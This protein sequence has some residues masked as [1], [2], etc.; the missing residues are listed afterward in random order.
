MRNDLLFTGKGHAGTQATLES[1]FTV[2]KIYDAPDRD[3]LLQGLRER[4]RPPAEEDPPAGPGT[5]DDAEERQWS[6]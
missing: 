6:S 4:R 1:E 3:A 2:H 5:D